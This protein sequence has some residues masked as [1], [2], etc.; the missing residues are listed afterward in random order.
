MTLEI[1]WDLDQWWIWDKYW[2]QDI[3]IRQFMLTM[4]TDIVNDKGF[5][6]I[7]SETIL[8]YTVFP[9]IKKVGS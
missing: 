5:T 6:Q 1:N 4:L 3:E 9:I 2:T 7:K 8:K